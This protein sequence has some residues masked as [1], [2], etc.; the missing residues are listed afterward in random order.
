MGRFMWMYFWNWIFLLAAIVLG[1]VSL[2]TALR[3]RRISKEHADRE[4][5][6]ESKIG[7]LERG[8]AGLKSLVF[9]Q[10]RRLKEIEAQLATIAGIE[11]K[12]EPLPTYPDVKEP[13]AVKIPPE[14]AAP[15]LE[16]PEI[17]ISPEP[18][19]ESIPPLAARATGPA[20]QPPPWW[21][22]LEETVGRDRKSVV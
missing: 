6:L 14:P 22:N 11:T 4:H 17:P 13:E 15:A 7:A 19:P 1:I 20:G 8:V 18:Q 5:K 16:M 2:V 9:D 10:G 21:E 3:S 12:K